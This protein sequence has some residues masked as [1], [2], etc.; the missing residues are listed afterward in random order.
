VAAVLV[1]LS[2]DTYALFFSIVKHPG[3]QCFK[4]VIRPRYFGIFFSDADV[5]AGRILLALVS[6]VSTA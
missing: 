4:S 6:I 1:L 2:V 3:V 5:V